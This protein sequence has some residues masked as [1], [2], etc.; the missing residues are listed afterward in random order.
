MNL[1]SSLTAY[2]FFKNKLQALSVYVEK[3][4]QLEIFLNNSYTELAY[5]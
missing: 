1:C 3:T 2:Y 5:Y 4:R